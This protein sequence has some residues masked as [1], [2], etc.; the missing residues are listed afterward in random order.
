M[1]T[2]LYLSYALVLLDTL[3]QHPASVKVFLAFHQKKYLRLQQILL[4]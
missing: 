4:L 3:S 2:T 1:C